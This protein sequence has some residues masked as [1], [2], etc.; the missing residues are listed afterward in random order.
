MHRGIMARKMRSEGWMSIW[1]MKV[2]NQI[3][4]EKEGKKE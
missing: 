3:D 4:M 1:V 2:K